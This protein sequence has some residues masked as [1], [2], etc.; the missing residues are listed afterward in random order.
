MKLRRFGQLCA[1]VQ[2]QKSS[3]LRRAFIISMTNVLG[4]KCL[5]GSVYCSMKDGRTTTTSLILRSPPQCIA[6]VKHASMDV[7]LIVHWQSHLHICDIGYSFSHNT[8]GLCWWVHLWCNSNQLDNLPC[9]WLWHIIILTTNQ[10]KFISS[11]G[12]CLELQVH[13]CPSHMGHPSIWKIWINF[14]IENF[15]KI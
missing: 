13:M 14:F 6:P 9:I 1:G 8:R 11:T 10:V 12:H 4:M 15:L 3:L 2:Y 5:F 7:Q